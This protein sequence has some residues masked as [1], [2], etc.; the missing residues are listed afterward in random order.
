LILIS[1]L[2]AAAEDV[3]AEQAELAGLSMAIRSRSI[4]S[5]YS[6]RM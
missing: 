3:V 5:G 1:R 6:A 4:A 2:E